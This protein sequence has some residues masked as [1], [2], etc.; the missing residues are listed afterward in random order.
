ME[1]QPSHNLHINPKA[2]AGELI[3]LA[4]KIIE[5]HSALGPESPL[6][7]SHIAALNYKVKCALDKHEE[8]M[9]YKKLMESAWRERDTL[10]GLSGNT[11]GLLQSIMNLSQAIQDSYGSS[12]RVL[13]QW[14]FNDNLLNRD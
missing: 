14:G 6:K 5:Q 3:I 9:K 12:K 2:E 10:M 11:E 8:G 4:Q 13:E 7:G 1:Q